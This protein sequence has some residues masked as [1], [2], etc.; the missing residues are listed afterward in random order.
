[1]EAKTDQKKV[2][3]LY[4]NTPYRCDNLIILTGI[5]TDRH[6][7]FPNIEFDRPTFYPIHLNR[8]ENRIDFTR[9]FVFQLKFVKFM[10]RIQ[11]LVA[12][13][14]L[15]SNINNVCFYFPFDTTSAV[16][17]ETPTQTKYI[18]GIRVL[19]VETSK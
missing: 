14:S 6:S 12:L 11:Q 3:F 8:I 19:S 13:E 2:F 16:V 5:H 15:I 1:M 18:N 17:T 7:I 4:S 10:Q 9:F